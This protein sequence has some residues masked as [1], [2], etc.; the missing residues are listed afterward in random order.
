VKFIANDFEEVGEIE[1][2]SV[3]ERGGCQQ[4]LSPFIKDLFFFLK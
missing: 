1:K 2:F 3:A 4:S